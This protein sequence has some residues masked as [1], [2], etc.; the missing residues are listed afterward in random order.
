MSDPAPLLLDVSRLIWRAWVGRRPTGVDRVCLAYLRHYGPRAQ[1]V[2]QHRHFRSILGRRAS[3]ALFALLDQPG[4]SFRR[5]FTRLALRHSASRR[6]D[7]KGRLYLNVGHTGLDQDGF[8]RW[9]RNAQVR[10]LYFVHD[11]I[12]ITH[13]H[14]CR[15][16]ERERHERRMRT[17]LDTAAGVIANSRATLQ[18]LNDFAAA[19]QR[20]AGPQ[21]A[22]FLGVTP[23]P[24]T[25]PSSRAPDAPSFVVLGTIEARKNHLFL[26]HLWSHLIERMGAA[27]PRLLIIGQRGWE[28]EQVEDWLDRSDRLR[29]RVTELNHCSDEE[30][31]AHLGSARALLFPSLAEGYGLPLV[32][33]LGA[34]VPVIASNLPVFREIGQDMVTLL[35]P[36]D[37]P[38]WE[39]E[40]LDYARPDSEA[41]DRQVRRLAEFHTPTWV[42]HFAT[43]DDWLVRF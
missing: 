13:P 23:L 5:D 29:T 10:P 1:A 19:E 42:D 35:N 40:V 15:A 26:L 8:G 2:V 38:S 7:G 14:L 27:A 17:V 4:P 30:L 24:R 16:G 21:L 31:A 39:R 41:R 3:A 36:L 22:A 11:L 34:G 33:A 43:V 18:D 28:A 20:R 32:E 6:G 9:V 12:P 37:G 25:A